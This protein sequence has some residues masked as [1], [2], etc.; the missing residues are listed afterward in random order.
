MITGG[1]GDHTVKVWHRENPTAEYTCIETYT[2]HTSVVSSVA[3]MSNGTIVS[4]SY[5]K[6]VK[7]WSREARACL[8][9]LKGHTDWV[10]GVAILPGGEVVSASN[11]K[12]LKIWI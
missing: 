7:I 5:D 8:H 6:T 4:S 10:N 11:D 1:Y 2:G 12:T 9:T 3:V